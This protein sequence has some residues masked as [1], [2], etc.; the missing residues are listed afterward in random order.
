M[1]SNNGHGIKYWLV[2]ISL[3]MIHNK[4][5]PFWTNNKQHRPI[6]NTK[7]LVLLQLHKSH[8]LVAHHC[9][10]DRTEANFPAPWS[11][12]KETKHTRKYAVYRTYQPVAWYPI[13]AYHMR[14]MAE[15][16]RTNLSDR[17]CKHV[18]TCIYLRS[19]STVQIL[20]HWLNTRPLHPNNNNQHN[21]WFTHESSHTRTNVT[22]M[23]WWYNRSF[24]QFSATIY[25]TQINIVVSYY[26]GMLVWSRLLLT[27]SC[28]AQHDCRQALRKP[29]ELY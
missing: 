24:Y 10:D 14:P 17:A 27:S 1:P 23:Y 9:T 20:W 22:A 4:S 26:A 7:Y 3:M 6:L 28:R 29:T 15:I 18:A 8:T 25:S 5:Q 19:L 12:P 21:R 11:N 2:Q 13:K 16:I